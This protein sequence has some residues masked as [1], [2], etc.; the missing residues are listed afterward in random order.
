MKRLICM[1]AFLLCLVCVLPAQEREVK[2]KIV[3]TSDVHGNYFPYNFI[4]Q[5][6]WGGSLARV[7]ALVQKNRE[8][9]K[10]TLYCWITEIFCKDSLRH[11]II[12]I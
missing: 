9:Y 2:L 12:I 7:Y 6:E 10:E 5:K 1:Y 4:T 11:T 8:V 3:Q